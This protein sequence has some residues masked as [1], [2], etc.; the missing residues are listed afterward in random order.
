[1]DD[2]IATRQVWWGEGEAAEAVV[3]NSTEVVMVRLGAKN[4]WA[5]MEERSE[6]QSDQVSCGL[7]GVDDHER[8][9]KRRRDATVGS[10][11]GAGGQ[12]RHTNEVRV[13][14]GL[15][16]GRAGNCQYFASEV[17]SWRG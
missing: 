9:V 5:R 1:M 12:V 10:R 11:F 3:N 13:T 14:E 7:K 15:H 6:A 16:L 2:E 8:V 4:A 17:A